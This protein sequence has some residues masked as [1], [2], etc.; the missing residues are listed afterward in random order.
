MTAISRA[1]LLALFLS[2]DAHAQDGPPDAMAAADTP[3]PSP[4]ITRALSTP[5]DSYGVPEGLYAVDYEMNAIKN[6]IDSQKRSLA[7]LGGFGAAF[8]VLGLVT[9]AAAPELVW[10]P[11][12][13]MT[14]VPWGYALAGLGAGVGLYGVIAIP[15]GIQ[16]NKAALTRTFESKY[17][18][19]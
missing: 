11:G 12:G 2:V 15:P 18:Q 10:A 3:T 16:R 4:A 6:S 17:K 19:D 14:E 9:G 5:T 1:A 8:V 13:S 7:L